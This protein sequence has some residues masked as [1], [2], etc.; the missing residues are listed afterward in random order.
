MWCDKGF[1]EFIFY[2]KINGIRC[3]YKKT[4]YYYKFLHEM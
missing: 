1:P 2:L 4:P 3:Y